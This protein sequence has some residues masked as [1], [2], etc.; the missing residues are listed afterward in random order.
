MT[1]RPT[2]T[3][4]ALKERARTSTRKTKGLSL[5]PR[6]RVRRPTREILSRLVRVL[7][8]GGED[9]RSLA[10]EFERVCEHVRARPIAKKDATRSLEHGQVIARWYSEPEYVDEVG[11]PRAL[12]FSGSRHSLSALIARVLPQAD[13]LSVLEDLKELK[14]VRVQGR[15]YRPTDDVITFRRR[16]QLIPWLLTLLSGTLRTIEHNA[17]CRPEDR[18]PDRIAHN[19]RFPVDQLPKY[20]AHLRKRCT[21]FLR[22]RDREMQRL[23]RRGGSSPR[24]RLAVT[25]LAFEGP[26]VPERTKRKTKE[27]ARPPRARRRRS[28]TR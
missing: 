13:P 20:Y 11:H 26:M 9:P 4:Q 18:I 22:E 16:D 24:T 27:G 21:G 3:V 17:T 19:P 5:L 28:G 14:A 10:Q 1:T 25:V 15:L 7:A 12:P 8:M 6:S 23:E 2:K